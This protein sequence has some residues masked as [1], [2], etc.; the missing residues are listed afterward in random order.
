MTYRWDKLFAFKLNSHRNY[1]LSD[2]SNQILELFMLLLVFD[3]SESD[4]L[5]TL[6]EHVKSLTKLTL[7]S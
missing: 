4:T 7:G 6:P 2:S 5:H 1:V 3:H